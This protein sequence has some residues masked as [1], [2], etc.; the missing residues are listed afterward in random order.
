V[1]TQAAVALRGIDRLPSVI[2]TVVA[3]PD[4]NY[5][6]EICSFSRKLRKRRMSVRLSESTI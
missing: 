1:D 3:D 5:L 4:G 6:S 2:M